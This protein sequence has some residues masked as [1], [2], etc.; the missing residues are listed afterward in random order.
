[1]HGDR[2]T[3]PV[4]PVPE[5]TKQFFLGLTLMAGAL[6][7][8]NLTTAA[9]QRY[10]NPVRANIEAAAD[11]M[12]ADKYGYKLT[13]GQMSFAEWLLHSADRNFTDCA[14]LKGE[15][16]PMTSAQVNA[17][18]GKDAVA[19]TVKDSFAYCA[20][21]LQALDDKKVTST[22]ELSY[23]FLHTIVHNNEI[24]GNLVGYLRTSEIIPPSTARRK[25]AEIKR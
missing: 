11:Q 16:A 9:I 5:M 10:F 12:P 19:K 14:T 8:Q 2:L 1:M 18:K 24:Y 3:S 13:P 6:H 17:M 4:Y 20:S 21:A 25:A 22:S 23:S 15:T 7:A